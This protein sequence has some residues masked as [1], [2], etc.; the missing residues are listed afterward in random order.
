MMRKTFSI[1]ILLSFCNYVGCVST[2]PISVKEV[3]EEQFKIN[4]TEEIF[5]TTVDSTRYHFGAGNYKIE[6]DTLHGVGADETTQP[7]KQF[8][9]SIPLSEIVNFEQYHFTE[10]GKA[11][12]FIGLTA[13]FVGSLLLI[14]YALAVDKAAGGEF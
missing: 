4:F 10:T 5:I 8:K 9:G 1:L 13:I 7:I 2:G 6:E 14:Y 12:T 11:I 3:R